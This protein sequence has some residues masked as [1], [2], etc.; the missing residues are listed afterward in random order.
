MQTLKLTIYHRGFSSSIFYAKISQIYIR[1]TI[2]PRNTFRA[3]GNTTRSP[4]RSSMPQLHKNSAVFIKTATRMRTSPSTPEK[5]S[6]F[7]QTLSKGTKDLQS[8]PPGLMTLSRSTV[9]RDYRRKSETRKHKEKTH[10]FSHLSFLIR[11]RIQKDI[12]D[13]NIQSLGRTYLFKTTLNAFGGH[14]PAGD[15]SGSFMDLHPS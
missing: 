10:R 3:S 14:I 8:P 6:L 9:S 12:F 2:D 5:N 11:K 1:K 15:S 4:A 7:L 13:K